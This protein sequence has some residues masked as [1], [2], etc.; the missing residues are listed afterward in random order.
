MK[1]TQSIVSETINAMIH[2][3]NTTVEQLEK[4]IDKQKNKAM[5]TVTKMEKE[6]QLGENNDAISL[7]EDVMVIE[8]CGK[9]AKV[10]GQ[11]CSMKQ[12]SG[13]INKLGEILKKSKAKN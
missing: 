13:V 9:L 12:M 4:E 5:E 10:Y 8:G 11:I 7:L 6:L 1:E 3:E 2:D